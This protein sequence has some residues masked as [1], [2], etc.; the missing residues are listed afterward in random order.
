MIFDKL[1]KNKSEQP[2]RKKAALIPQNGTLID[3]LRNT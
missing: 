2:Q 3:L 1:F